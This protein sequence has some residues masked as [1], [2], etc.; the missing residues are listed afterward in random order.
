MRQQ[1][2]EP[3][4]A[5]LPLRNNTE[6]TVQR[7]C[8]TKGGLVEKIPGRRLIKKAEETGNEV[9][10]PMAQNL[11]LVELLKRLAKEIQEDHL[12]AFAGNLTY[13]G[14]FAL[15]PFFVFLLS[16]L[17]LFGAPDLLRD[18]IDRASGVLPQGAVGFLEDQ[19]LGIASTKA[20]GAFT[21]GAG[22][23]PPLALWGGSGAFLPGPSAG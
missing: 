22:G 19:L 1:T 14:L 21:V 12:A 8:P 13:K 23:L 3:Q 10:V 9:E 11:G 20:Q 2:A 6:Q 18:L 5:D 4:P 17:G 16:L 15:F 7:R